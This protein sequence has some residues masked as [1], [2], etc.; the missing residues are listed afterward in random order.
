M[1]RKLSELL[2]KRKEQEEKGNHEFMRR[3][4]KHYG[5]QGEWR[6]IIDNKKY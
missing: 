6:A 2:A 3:N 4:K 5:D 1:K